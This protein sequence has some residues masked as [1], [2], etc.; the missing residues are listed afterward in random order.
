MGIEALEEALSARSFVPFRIVL[1]SDPALPVP[2]G[3]FVSISPNRRWVLVWNKRGGWGLVDP[4]LI[5]E[6]AFNG[7]ARR[8]RT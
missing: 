4:T 7:T 5:V 8:R 3:D 1:P 6:L 2:Y